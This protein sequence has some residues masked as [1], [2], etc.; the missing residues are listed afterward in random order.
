MGDIASA[1]VNLSIS[2]KTSPGDFG[3]RRGMYS[4]RWWKLSGTIK[5]LGVADHHSI[6]FRIGIDETAENAG[7]LNIFGKGFGDFDQ[8]IVMSIFF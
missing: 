1:V 3:D 2:S 5:S 6:R 7:G 8:D 4:P